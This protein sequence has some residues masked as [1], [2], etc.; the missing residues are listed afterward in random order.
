MGNINVNIRARKQ[1]STLHLLFDV[2]M[3]FLTG[4]LWLIWLLIRFLRNN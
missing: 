2:L 3:V 1:Y 4:G